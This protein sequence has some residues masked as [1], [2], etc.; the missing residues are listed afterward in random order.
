[1]KK[2]AVIEIGTN[3][4]KLC[5]ARFSNDNISFF[6][7]E[8]AFTRIGDLLFS[9]TNPGIIINNLIKTIDQF[10]IIAKQEK[11]TAIHCIATMAFRHLIENNFSLESIEFPLAIEI[12]SEKNEAYFSYLAG[13]YMFPKIPYALVIDSGGGS[14]ECM[15]LNGNQFHFMSLP[16]GAISATKVLEQKGK[17]AIYNSIEKYLRDFTIPNLPIEIIGIGGT[18]NTLFQMKKLFSSSDKNNTLTISDIKKQEEYYSKSDMKT[19]VKH[20][21]MHEKR[22]DIILGGLSIIK[23]LLN[24]FKK[25]EL[26]VSSFG[27]RH[28]YILNK[29][30]E[31]S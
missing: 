13:K 5:I 27:V 12:L 30:G 7:K 22:A 8:I 24:K 19:I 16:I 4:T 26:L 18:I 25:S 15:Y 3:S 20:T 17:E 2:I 1:M 11:C 31:L 6:R 28:G 14:T 9:S 23:A 21:S 10:Y 29:I